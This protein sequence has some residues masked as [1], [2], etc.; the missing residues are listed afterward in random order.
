MP[1]GVD[2]GLMITGLVII[3]IAVIVGL[4]VKSKF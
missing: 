1:P 3:G 4:V 2:T